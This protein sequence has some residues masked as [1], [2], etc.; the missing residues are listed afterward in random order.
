VDV[1]LRETCEHCGKEP[2]QPSARDWLDTVIKRVRAAVGEQL[3]AFDLM[4]KYG[5]GTLKAI[6]DDDIRA[7]LSKQLDIIR[8]R[9]SP[10]EAESLIN[11][12]ETAWR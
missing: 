10:E 5:I 3:K 7:R 4:G 2:T 9:L 11:E 1:T 6:T 12:I 8:K